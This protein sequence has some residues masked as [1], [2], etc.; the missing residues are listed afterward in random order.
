MTSIIKMAVKKIRIFFDTNFIRNTKSEEFDILLSTEAINQIIKFIDTNKLSKNITIVIADIILEERIFQKLETINFDNENLKNIQ[1]KYKKYFNIEGINLK[2][3]QQFDYYQYF[4][5]NCDEFIKKI[6]FE[7]VKYPTIELK[8]II[9]RAVNKQ[10]PFSKGGD[11]GFKDTILW[12]TILEDAKQHQ[13]TA[14]VLC[15]DDQIFKAQLLEEEFLGIN[16]NGIITPKDSIEVQE[17]L[18]D[19]F[20]EDT[21]YR[22][23]IE[24]VK[25]QVGLK[26]GDIMVELHKS[27]FEV[28]SFGDFQKVVSLSFENMNVLGITETEKNYEI[29]LD[30]DLKANYTYT[31]SYESYTRPILMKFGT[32][33]P[34]T[35]ITHVIDFTPSST[36]IPIE[37]SGS[38]FGEKTT[39][40]SIFVK[41]RV[42][43]SLE[44]DFKTF[45]IV[46]LQPDSP[47][48]VK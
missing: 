43:I 39:V 32:A 25:R 24:E 20:K 42:S 23:R 44:K 41:M 31:S 11:K 14:Y 1:E 3:F 10:P 5:K 34:S 9:K 16:K 40:N 12:Y 19:V 21:K 8:T 7:R 6:N 45:K 17:Y 33:L 46:Y 22:Q 4:E 35:A 26:I 28:I 36:A 30:L 29:I 37:T 18:N 47:L 27:R 13:D 38:I 15:T 48:F 2:N